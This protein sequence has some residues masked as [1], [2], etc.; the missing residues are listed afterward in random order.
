DLAAME[1]VSSPVLS[2]DGRQLV[3]VQRSVDLDANTSTTALY[4]R[5]LVTR[6]LGPPK[7]LTPEGWNVNSPA[8]SPDGQTVYFL[9]AKGGSQQLYAMPLSGGTPRQLTAFEA[10]VGTFHISP[11]GRRV[12]FSA[13]VFGECGAD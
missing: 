7:R 6:D 1:R 9:S 12:A 5:H 8:F 3:F 11:D 13:D 4:T 2:P 10:D